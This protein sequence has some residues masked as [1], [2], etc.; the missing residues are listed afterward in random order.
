[1]LLPRG[2]QRD[3]VLVARS[4][5]LL[6]TVL[7]KISYTLVSYSPCPLPL[8]S[9]HDK[10]TMPSLDLLPGDTNLGPMTSLGQNN[11]SATKHSPALL[12]CA[13]PGK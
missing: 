9:G 6:Y 5:D 11:G 4:G 8:L 1:M 10:Y 7:L 13:M 2:P 3:K 12:N